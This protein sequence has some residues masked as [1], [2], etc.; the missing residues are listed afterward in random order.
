MAHNVLVLLDLGLPFGLQSKSKVTFPF[1]SSRDVQ[2]SPDTI[3][4]GWSPSYFR[5]N[6]AAPMQFESKLNRPWG[7]FA[8]EFTYLYFCV[9]YGEY[10]YFTINK[11]S[12][13][14]FECRVR[15][16]LTGNAQ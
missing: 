10:S 14:S 3:P 7:H 5:E 12:F 2:D 15:L 11:Y 13:N 1:L 8:V 9:P 16:N 4:T 6:N